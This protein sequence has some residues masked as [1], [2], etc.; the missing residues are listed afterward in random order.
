MYSDFDLWQVLRR[1]YP[2]Q[3]FTQHSKCI[4]Q[5]VPSGEVRIMLL[6]K[7]TQLAP[8]LVFLIHWKSGVYFLEKPAR[9]RFSFIIIFIITAEKKKIHQKMWPPA[10][11]LVGK[12]S[13][14]HI[15]ERNSIFFSS[16]WSNRIFFSFS[17]C[18]FS[19][20]QIFKALY[21]YLQSTD[22]SNFSWWNRKF[23][24]NLGL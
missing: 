18:K 8:L 11:H 12:R 6:T 19:L 9:Y 4:S 3:C 24:I 7:L 1:G 15:Q 20:I 13:N 2:F 23:K 17:V 10:Y 21:I 5:A 14:E 22:R 16:S